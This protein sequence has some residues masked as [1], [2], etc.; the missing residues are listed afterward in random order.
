MLQHLDIWKK[1]NNEGK[2][3]IEKAEKP[4]DVLV[5]MNDIVIKIKWFLRNLVSLG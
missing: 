5:K 4:W 3:I 2:V 1:L